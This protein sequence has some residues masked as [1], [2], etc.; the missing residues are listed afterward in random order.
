MLWF[1]FEVAQ[2]FC[3]HDLQ[4]GVSQQWYDELDSLAKEIA[5]PE[6]A[7]EEEE[8]DVNLSEIER[9]EDGRIH[10]DCT[11]KTSPGTSEVRLKSFLKSLLSTK[12]KVYY[13][14][15]YNFVDSGLC[16]LL[17]MQLCI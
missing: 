5:N 2:K 6:A 11:V 15:E 12:A 9:E 13:I 7:E 10:I 17:F 1:K 8:E 4:V 16:S 14:K 3:F